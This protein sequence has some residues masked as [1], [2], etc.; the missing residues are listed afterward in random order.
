MLFR[1]RA[2]AA[3]QAVGELQR[4]LRRNHQQADAFERL[5]FEQGDVRGVGD[6]L[7]EFLVADNLN[8]RE[9][10]VALQPEINGQ[11]RGERADQLFV[12]LADAAQFARGEKTGLAEIVPA[13]EVTAEME[14]LINLFLENHAH[15]SLPFTGGE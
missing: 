1:H 14:L 13:L 2:G 8:F 11:A 12:P 3:E 7:G 10:E 9:R 5:G 4:E 6:A 15:H